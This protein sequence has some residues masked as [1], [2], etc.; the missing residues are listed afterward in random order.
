MIK[1]TFDSTP[2]EIWKSVISTYLGVL[3]IVFAKL[4]ET[5]TRYLGSIQS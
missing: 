1:E 3:S 4:S 2:S 5:Q